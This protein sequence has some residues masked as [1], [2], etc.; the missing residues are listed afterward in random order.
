[1]PLTNFQDVEMVAFVHFVPPYGCISGKG[2]ADLLTQP[3]L[4]VLP[5][6]QF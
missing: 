4:E 3:Y 1:M 6:I 5:I 2:F